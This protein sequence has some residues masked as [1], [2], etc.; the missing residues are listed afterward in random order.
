MKQL[1]FI[2]LIIISAWLF[3]PPDRLFI[4]ETANAEVIIVANRSVPEDTISED[5]LKDIFMG[6]TLTWD[7]SQEIKS[8]VL[9]GGSTHEDFIKNYLH[10]TSSQFDI[11]WKKRMF[12]GK[13]TPPHTVQSE[14][15]IID[16]VAATKGAISYLSTEPTNDNIKVIKITR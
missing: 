14:S 6:I 1:F 5:V 8:V 7:D 4:P 12:T 10:K 2:G 15:D 3:F 11:Y 13:G 16:Y 9:Q